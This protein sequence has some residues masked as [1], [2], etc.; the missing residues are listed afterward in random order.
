MSLSAVI[1]QHTGHRSYHYV[2]MSKVNKCRRLPVSVVATRRQ[3][4]DREVS[5]HAASPLAG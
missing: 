3:C 5:C 1:A 2:F 4:I